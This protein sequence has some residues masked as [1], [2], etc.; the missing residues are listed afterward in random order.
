[1]L[2]ALTKQNTPFLQAVKDQFSSGNQCREGAVIDAVFLKKMPRAAFFEIGKF[3]IGIVYGSEL[4]DSKN[5]VKDM[6]PG[7][8]IHARVEAIDGYM[9]Y[10][11]L[12]LSEAGKQKAWQ[13]VKTL[14]ESGE[15]AHVKVTGV[16]QGGLL[17]DLFGLKA[18][19][20]ASQLATNHAPKDTEGDRKK[21]MEELEKLIGE[22]LEIKVISVIPRNNK[23]ILSERETA[24]G[25]ENVSELLARYAVGQ[26]VSGIV[27]G[28]ADFGVFVRFTDTPEIEGLVHIS[29]IDHRIIDSPK[30]ILRVDEQVQVKIID[31]KEGRVFLSLKAL[32]SDPWEKVGEMYKEGQAVRGKA[33]KF[34]PFGVVVDLEG[35]LQGLVHVS[36]YG[37]LEEMKAVLK[38]GESYDFSIT[39][40]K[41]DEKRIILKPFDKAQGK[42]FDKTQGRPLEK[43]PPQEASEQAG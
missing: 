40:V 8:H 14:E 31:I 9:G 23:L 20:P 22:E 29:E 43:S 26:V 19:I 1:M 42:P 34:N 25:G 33:Y 4:Q 16:N 37:G 30:E 17:A 41:P 11:E 36:E 32:K 13:E 24:R 7:D 12:S 39:A 10:I 28:I 21:I 35:G 2:E 15:T 5:I 38:I 18:F 27:S 3:G 6:K